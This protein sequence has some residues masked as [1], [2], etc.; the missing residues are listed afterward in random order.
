M[1]RAFPF[2]AI[3]AAA[4]W[5]NEARQTLVSAAAVL[6]EALPFVLAGVLAERVARRRTALV[7]YAG[8]G[9]AAGPSAR[10]LPAAALAWLS[11]GPLVALGRV[12]AA[13][14]VDCCLRRRHAHRCDAH[15]PD[16]ANELERLL[17][18]AVLAAAGAQIAARLD[19]SHAHLA[20]QIVAGAVMGSIASPC[21]I[22]S[23]AVAAAMRAHASAAATA[24]LCVAGVADVHAFRSDSETAR[25]RGDA[26]AYAV[27]AIGAGLVAYRHGAELIR[28]ALGPLLAVCAIAAT[29]L[30]FK[31]RNERVRRIYAAPAAIVLGVLIATPPPVYRATETTLADVFPGERLSFTGEVTRDGRGAALVR[32]A[33]VCCRADAAPVVVRLA[34][35]TSLTAGTWARAD[36][37]V[38]TTPQGFALSSDSVTPVRAPADPFLYR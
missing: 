31:R 3:L 32:Y 30:A 18:F 35:P 14:I 13:A 27:L 19:L 28:P 12:A 24:F 26:F 37:I 1:R 11:F 23:I 10:S 25:G 36:G 15:A 8:C 6:V 9:C 4:V 22:G 7:A 38:V 2:A 16:L 34:R 5:P 21:A 20:L 29:M 17:P 33:I